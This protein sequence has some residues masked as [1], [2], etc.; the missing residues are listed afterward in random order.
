MSEE[1]PHRRRKEEH[2]EEERHRDTTTVKKSLAC[3]RKVT[4]PDLDLMPGNREG[5]EALCSSKGDPLAQIKR[6]EEI[7]QHLPG[8]REENKSQVE[9][10]ATVDVGGDKKN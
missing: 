5:K 8:T 7:P 2:S 9:L 6:Y 3:R 4:E 10:G 1:M